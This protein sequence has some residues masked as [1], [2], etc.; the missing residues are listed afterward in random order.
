MEPEAAYFEQFR[1]DPPWTP[2]KGTR[3]EVKMGPF[4]ENV[5]LVGT[6]AY[7]GFDDGSFDVDMDDPNW[8]G[9]HCAGML[10]GNVRVIYPEKEA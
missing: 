7:E 5:I 2:P 8:P 3:V 1:G 9:I 10:N 4:W 6:V